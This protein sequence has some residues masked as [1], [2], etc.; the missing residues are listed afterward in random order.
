MHAGSHIASQ[1][2]A[3]KINEI[4]YVNAGYPDN[5]GNA[6]HLH[7]NTSIQNRIA[8]LLSKRNRKIL[9]KAAHEVETTR[10]KILRDLEEARQVAKKARNGSAMAMCSMGMAK[11]QGLIIDRRE[12]GEVGS[13]ANMTDEELVEAIRKKSEALGLLLAVKRTCSLKAATRICDLKLF[14]PT[15]STS[16]TWVTAQRYSQRLL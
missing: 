9:E 6:S 2:P 13:F 16:V 4:A 3:A 1:L 12:V 14:F 8:E 11:V 10:E 7:S 15:Q 5:A